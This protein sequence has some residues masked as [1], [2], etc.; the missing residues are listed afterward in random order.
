MVV[1]GR[2]GM[3]EISP[4]GVTDAWEIRDGTTRRATIEPEAWSLP[5]GGLGELAGGEPA[6]NA[7]LTERILSG[8]DRSVRRTAVVVNAAAALLVSAVGDQ[9]VCLVALDP[10]GVPAFGGA[11]RALAE[12]GVVARVEAEPHL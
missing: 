2:A 1:Y 6:D 3:D 7:A 5:S 9:T 12:R 4:I 8:E 10:G 11:M